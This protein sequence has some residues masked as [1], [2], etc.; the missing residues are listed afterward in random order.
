MADSPTLPPAPSPS[1]LID[2]PAG[3]PATLVLAHGAGAPMDSPFMAA[4]ATGLAERGW[5]VVR[6]EFPYMARQRLSGRKSPPDTLP[7]L[8]ERFRAEVALAAEEATAGRAAGPLILG[9]KSLGGRVASLL[10]DELAP[11]GVR[12]CLC[13]GYPFHPPGKPHQPRTDHL[14]A[15]VTPTLIVQGE[16]DPFG[17]RDE[18]E[19]YPLSPRVRVE[20]IPSGDHSFKPNR[21]S[22][23]SEADTRALAVAL[24]D[25]FCR[26]L[27]A[28][29]LN[30]PGFQAP[31]DG[32]PESGV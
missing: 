2:G 17:R 4:I 18:V 26:E 16:R 29:P 21:T 10:V 28:D 1:R 23:L 20:W 12:G 9:G 32:P 19:A 22:G 31:G 13:L 30:G 7:K 24:A 15:L 14:A 5:R 27:L 11:L 6:F 8:L 25:R 3:A